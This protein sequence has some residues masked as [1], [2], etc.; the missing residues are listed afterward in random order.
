MTVILAPTPVTVAD[1]PQLPFLVRFRLKGTPWIPILI[2][3][4]IIVAAMGG[5]SIAP[6][7]PNGLDLGAAFRPPFWQAGGSY[8][9]LLGTDN[10]GRDVL[11]RIIAGARVSAIVVLYAIGFSGAIGTMLGIMA[12]YFGGIVDMI[13]VRITE[14]MMAIPTLALALIFTATMDP[15]LS[16]VIIVIVLTY[17]TWYARIIRSEI[18]SLRERD[19]VAF[20]KVAGCGP[21]TIFLRHLVP[22]IFNTLVV[23]M[24][25][26]V[27]QVII[28]E[29]S[30]SFLGVGIQPP[31]TSWGLMLAD[32]RQYITYAW[33]G[34]TMP[35]IAIILTCLSSNLIGDWLR[36]L[37]DP[38]R[39]Q[40]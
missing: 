29:A 12:G 36:D 28:F 15:G 37:L 40:L 23:L 3:L 16:T 7:D 13:I 17:W 14:I 34:I 8:D 21:V 10:L 1:A 20:A 38:K 27:G 25:L 22:N 6:H 2:L 5:E 24:T 9:Y 18:L 35:G 4:L 11:S 31:D 33:W 32:A 39:R 19:Y 30:L 26:Q